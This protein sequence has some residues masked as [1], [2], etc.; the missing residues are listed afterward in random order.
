VENE[1][2]AHQSNARIWSRRTPF[3]IAREVGGMSDQK[4]P[5][6]ENGDRVFRLL[7]HYRNGRGNKFENCVNIF[8]LAQGTLSPN[9]SQKID[10]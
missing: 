8:F 6:A 1:S 9:P 3:G 5:L 2:K 7:S 4:T 10:N